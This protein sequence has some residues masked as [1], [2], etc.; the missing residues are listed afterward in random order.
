MP[1]K[2]LDPQEK[3][4][5]GTHY[6]CRDHDIE[7][8]KAGAAHLMFAFPRLHHCARSAT[9]KADKPKGKLMPLAIS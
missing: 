9:Q 5:G 1:R 7:L 4:D 3:P 6:G 8:S 2:N